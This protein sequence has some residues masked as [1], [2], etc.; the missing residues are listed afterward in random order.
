MKENTMSEP[1]FWELL[2]AAKQKGEDPDGQVEWL[3]D[4]LSKRAIKE[5]VMF[6]FHFNHNYSKSYTSNLWAAAYIIMGGA[7]DDSFDYFRAWLLYQ[8]K[9]A[10]ESVIQYPEKII[11]HLKVLEEEGDVPQFEDLLS[12]GSIAYEEKTGLDY[13][14][15]YDLY[16]KLTVDQ[17]IPPDIELDWDEDDEEGLKRKYPAL[18]ARYGEQPLEYL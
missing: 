10:Y 17:N 1:V 2:V 5:I 12:V 18:W 13:D 14:D 11:P 4:Y 6:D 15:Y 8:G 9:D 16:E 7:A 3:V